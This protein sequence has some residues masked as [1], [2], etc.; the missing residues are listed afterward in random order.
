MTIRFAAKITA[1]AVFSASVSAEWRP[2]YPPEPYEPAFTLARDLG[3]ASSA[4]RG[5]VGR[6]SSVRGA[7]EA[8]APDRLRH[9]IR[10][11]EDPG[12]PT[13]DRFPPDRPQTFARSRSAHA[14]SLVGWR[15]PLQLVA[16]GAVCS[17]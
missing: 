9:G 4:P 6:T 7:L 10:A 3:L 16:A 15:R 17:I 8:L 2:E 11:A 5:E 13:R 12:L 14:R 1:S